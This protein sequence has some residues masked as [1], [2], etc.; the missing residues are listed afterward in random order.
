MRSSQTCTRG[1]SG[2]PSQHLDQRMR[3]IPLKCNF[4]FG[5][6]GS[7]RA[8]ICQNIEMS[9]IRMADLNSQTVALLVQEYRTKCSILMGWCLNYKRRS[10]CCGK[11]QVET[12][13]LK[14]LFSKEFVSEKILFLSAT[15]EEM[16]EWMAGH[17]DLQT[18]M[19]SGQLPE[20]ARFN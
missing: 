20:V 18:A 5:R 14:G 16:E 9:K 1:T 12:T 6:V 3:V 7:Q 2:S 19:A 10:T 11:F 17:A 13:N 15:N 8:K 4:S